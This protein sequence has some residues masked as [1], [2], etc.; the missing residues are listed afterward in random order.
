[1]KP[2]PKADTL[3]SIDEIEKL[4]DVKTTKAVSLLRKHEAPAHGKRGRKFMYS[5]ADVT[6]VMKACQEDID[7]RAAA[8][9]KEEKKL[10]R[11]L[12]ITNHQPV[13]LGDDTR[14]YFSI[15]IQRLRGAISE[16]EEFIGEMELLDHGKETQD[17]STPKIQPPRVSK[18]ETKEMVHKL[19]GQL[20]LFLEGKDKVLTRDIGS[21]LFP[22]RVSNGY[23]NNYINTLMGLRLWT[24]G[25]EQ[26]GGGKPCT[27]WFKNGVDRLK[28]SK[29][30]LLKSRKILK[31]DPNQL[32]LT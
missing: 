2:F 29:V 14:N 20:N 21:V 22:G 11:S 28:P 23:T 12:D 24:R 4:L 16:M 32:Q 8:K 9:A 31:D 25:S 10:L 7:S 17:V 19:N 1:M 27:C 18:Y 5:G 6:R 15:L 3:L 13:L 30:K 26:K